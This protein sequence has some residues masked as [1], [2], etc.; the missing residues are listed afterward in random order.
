M[1]CISSCLLLRHA[2]VEELELF[3]SLIRCCEIFVPQTCFEF[4]VNTNHLGS[5]SSSGH[6]ESGDM[7]SLAGKTMMRKEKTHDVLKATLCADYLAK[8]VMV[9]FLNYL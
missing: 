2:Y 8:L 1:I 6:Q 9:R 5:I 7:S 3:H 4:Y